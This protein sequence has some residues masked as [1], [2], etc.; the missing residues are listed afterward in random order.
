M[1]HETSAISQTA[2]STLE[3]LARAY[4][5]GQSE[6]SEFE[7]SAILRGIQAELAT[8]EILFRSLRAETPSPQGGIL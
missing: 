1:N 2:T 3:R 5:S 7:S 6:L 8:R 4:E